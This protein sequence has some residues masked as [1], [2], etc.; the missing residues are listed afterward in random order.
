[1]PNFTLRPTLTVCGHSYPIFDRDIPDLWHGFADEKGYEITARVRD[2]NHLVLRHEIC[3]LEMV[4]K[5]FVLRTC[6]PIC[7]HCLEVARRELCRAA[8]VTYLGRG[9]R[10]QYLRIRLACGHET[11]RQTELLQRV[12]QEQTAIR[13]AVCLEERLKREAAARDW[14]LIGSDPDGNLNYRLYRHD[15]GHVQ[16]V[17]IANM[18]TGR[19]ACGGCS[20]GWTRDPSYI[21]AMRFVLADGTDAIKVGFSRDPRSRL[22]FQLTTERDQYAMLLRTIEI[23]TGRDAIRMEKD[24]HLTLRRLYPDAVLDRTVF[25]GQVNCVSELYDS[26]IEAEIMSLLDALEIRVKGVVAR[27]AK[28]AKSAAAAMEADKETGPGSRSKRKTRKQR[29]GRF[30]QRNKMRR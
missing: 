28:A 22:Q 19:F 5:I 20:D 8:D 17:A 10:S 26:V 23:P 14:A 21:Y 3:G 12:R 30:R 1:M 4:T 24:L 6:V 16:R 27:R 15:C 25:A 9:D 7:P 11:E 29:R 13:C 18:R 2:K